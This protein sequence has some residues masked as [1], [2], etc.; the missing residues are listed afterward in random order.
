MAFSKS[1]AIIG[2]GVSGLAAACFLAGKGVS[3]NLFEAND[4]VGGSCNSD[5]PTKSRHAVIPTTSCPGCDNNPRFS[6]PIA[7]KPA[8]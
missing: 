1:V 7:L 3:V 8:G 4:K 5:W 6:S 2:G